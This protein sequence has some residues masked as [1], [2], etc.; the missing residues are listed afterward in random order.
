VTR[1]LTPDAVLVDHFDDALFT[2]PNGCAAIPCNAP[3]P[4]PVPAPDFIRYPH[5][6]GIIPTP[7]QGAQAGPHKPMGQRRR[8]PPHHPPPPKGAALCPFVSA[9]HRA[10]VQSGGGDDFFDE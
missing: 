9:V 7:P 8:P 4:F 5:V 1:W 3:V 2:V 6:A 10:H